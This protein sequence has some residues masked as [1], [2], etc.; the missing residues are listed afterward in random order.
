MSF[1]FPKVVWFWFFDPRRSVQLSAL[2]VFPRLFAFDFLALCDPLADGGSGRR[3]PPRRRRP[4]GEPIVGDRFGLRTGRC[5]RLAASG[6][7]HDKEDGS[8]E[9]WGHRVSLLECDPVC[10]LYKEDIVRMRVEQCIPIAPEIE[11]AD[12]RGIGPVLLPDEEDR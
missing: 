10:R 1:W 9:R 5:P 4:V 8:R 12:R 3:G 7:K 2:I 11:V 6:R